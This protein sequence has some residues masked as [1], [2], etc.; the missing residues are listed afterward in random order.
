MMLQQLRVVTTSEGVQAADSRVGL[1]RLGAWCTACDLCLCP[2]LLVLLLVLLLLQQRQ[3]LGRRQLQLLRA[4]V[5]KHA[6]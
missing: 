3:W 4:A 6:V 1:C 2:L 5:R